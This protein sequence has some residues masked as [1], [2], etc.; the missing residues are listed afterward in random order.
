MIEKYLGVPIPNEDI[1]G[2]KETHLIFNLSQLM[3]T[4][5]KL[6]L[7]V[8]GCLKFTQRKRDFQSIITA[9]I[10]LKKNRQ[11]CEKILNIINQRNAN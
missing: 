10:I 3:K 2:V 6:N 9:D 5:L 4:K 1:I 11:A 7:K 8:S